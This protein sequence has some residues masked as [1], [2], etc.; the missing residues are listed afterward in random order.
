MLPACWHHGTGRD[1]GQDGPCGGPEPTVKLS[2]PGTAQHGRT[3][4]G[5]ARRV[6]FSKPGFLGSSTDEEGHG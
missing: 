5:A 2:E 6:Y 4:G 3:D 1:M